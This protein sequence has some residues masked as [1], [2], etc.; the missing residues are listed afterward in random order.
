MQTTKKLCLLS[1]LLLLFGSLYTADASA[2]SNVSFHGVGVTINL[3][4]PPEAHPTD[5]LSHNLTIT[6]NSALTIQNFTIA[7]YAPVNSSWQLVKSQTLTSFDLQQNQNFTSSL[8]LNLPPETN[9]TLSCVIYI[10]TDRSAD[11]FSASF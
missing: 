10:L 11:Y 8:A 1:T 5:N 6:A 7:I 4:F 3:A 2:N 9:G